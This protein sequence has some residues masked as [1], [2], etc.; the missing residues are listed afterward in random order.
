VTNSDQAPRAFLEACSTKGRPQNTAL[1]DA[2]FKF[3]TRPKVSVCVIAYNQERYIRQCLQSLVDQETSFNF[4]IIVGDDC[5]TD[6]TRAILEEFARA[7][8]HLVRLIFQERNTGGTRNYLDVHAQACGDYV[9]HLD[10]DDL[11]LPGRLELQAR[12]L[13]LDPQCVIVWHRMRVFD[14]SGALSVPNLPSATIWPGGRIELRDLLRYGSVGYHSAMMYRAS[15]WA[16]KVDGPALDWYFAVELLRSGHGL[17]L[18][19]ILGGYRYNPT[20]GLSRAG[21]GTLRTRRLYQMHLQHYARELPRSRR[22]IFM[23]CLI[24][25]LVDVVNRRPTWIGF[26]RLALHYPSLV[27]IFKFPFSLRRYRVINPKIL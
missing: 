7:H 15:A 4:E 13:D 24:N 25:A 2:V 14:D 21:D 26:L 16:P 8:P 12:A 19:G 23:N 6:G 5:S 9:A 10:G 22:D 18:E 3:S 27:E 17:Y 1:D 11:A 20:T